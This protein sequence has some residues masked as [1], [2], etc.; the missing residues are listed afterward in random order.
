MQWRIYCPGNASRSCRGSNINAG[1][2]A[3]RKAMRGAYI[4][5][6]HCTPR[7][8]FRLVG[9]QLAK[10]FSGVEQGG[11]AWS[12]EP[13]RTMTTATA[14]P[15]C[16]PPMGPDGGGWDQ[17]CQRFGQARSQGENIQ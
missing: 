11:G 14:N 4:D 2:Q 16:L 5:E 10:T 13:Y 9:D 12:S 3:T 15:G 1:I 17:L 6:E 7:H 8:A